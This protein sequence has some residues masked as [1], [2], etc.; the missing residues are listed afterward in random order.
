MVPDSNLFC[1]NRIVQSVSRCFE[2]FPPTFTMSAQSEVVVK[3]GDASLTD[4]E[5]K[6]NASHE[7]IDH[8]GKGFVW[9][10]E[11]SSN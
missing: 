9:E 10:C 11:I 5:R 8:E 4:S 6:L 1:R 7:V 2:V 3:S